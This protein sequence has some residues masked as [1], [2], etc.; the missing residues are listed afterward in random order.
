MKFR[1]KSYKTQVSKIEK[2]KLYTEEEAIKLVK[3]VSNVKFDAT[4][5][6]AMNLNLD[7]KKAD[8]QLRG[9]IVL[10]K[11]TGKDAKVL[12]IAK[13][14]SAKEAVDAG[15]DFV[16]DADMIEKIQKENWFEFDT[17]IA[18]PEM[19]PL[20]GKIGKI[21]GPKGLMPNPKT[22]TVTTNVKQA[23]LDAKAGKLEYRTDSYGNVHG[24]I[25]KSS[26][27]ETML[28]ENL[29][30]FVNAILKVKP[31]TVKGNYVKNISV[32]ST[33]GPGIKI[34]LN[35]FDK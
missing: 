19:M 22:G 5:E 25:G 20:L 26:F 8:Q 11:G 16:G 15:A 23:V 1:G 21:L 18:T 4:I 13:G 2:N 28:V 10:P 30:A 34:D 29:T 17:L 24:I 32:S 9:A 31:S 7:V 27:T 12:V 14:D 3:E 33:M 35:S 6:V